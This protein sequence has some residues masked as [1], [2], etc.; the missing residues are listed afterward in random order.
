MNDELGF[1]LRQ[2][3]RGD[4][5]YC[6]DGE[7]RAATLPERVLWKA[8]AAPA[9]PAPDL[10][11]EIDARKA[12][13]IE[14]EALKARIARARLDLMDELK[15]QGW[16]PA[17]SAPAKPLTDEQIDRVIGH[18]ACWTG[19]GLGARFKKEVFARLIEKACAEAW[20]VKLG[21]AASKGEQA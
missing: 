13:Q 9:A 14:N 17:E 2:D 19:P 5:L 20:G 21:I 4:W 3:E 10:Q 12:A 11:R 16:A 8:L 7:E 15:E 6:E 1:R 18:S